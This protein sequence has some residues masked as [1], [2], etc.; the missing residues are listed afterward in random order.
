MLKHFNRMKSAHKVVVIV[1]AS[2]MG[3]SL[4]LFYAPAR[5]LANDV[6]TNTETLAQVNGDE[7]TVG[8]LTRL[9]ESYQQM[10]GGQM[11]LAQLGGDK[12]FLDGLIRDRIVTQ[13]ARR[14]NL[15]ASDAE[16]GA[17]IR[18]QFPDAA[19]GSGDGFDRYKDIVTTRY[20]SVEKFEQTIRDSLAE[21]KLR[22]F[23]TAGVNVSEAEVKDDYAHKNTA[24][25]LTYV[26]VVADKLAARVQPSDDELQKYYDAHK[27]DF[28]YLEAQKKVRYLFIDQAKL[29]AKLTI[30]DE[31]LR[32]EYNE[33]APDKKEAGVRAQQI[34]LKVA[35]PELDQPVLTK[36]TKIVADLRGDAG[37]A[38][39]IVDEKKFAD[40]ARGQSEDPTTAKNGGAL[41]APVKRNPVK[42]TDL[43]QRV[44]DLN[45][46]QTTDP[47]YDKATKAY[48]IFRRGAAVPKTFEDAKPELLA[49]LRNRRAYKSA[50]ELAGRAAQRLKETKDA[51]KVAAELASDAAMSP[52]EMI[53]ETPL[54]KPGDNVPDIGSSPQFEEAIK[55]LEN[56][57]DVG[58]RI[59]VKNGFA[60]PLL[61]EKRDPRIPDFAE[62]KDKVGERVKAEQAKG[63][64]EQA[65]RDI[66]NAANNPAGLK[67]AAEKYGLEVKTLEKYKTSQPL[68]GVGTSPAVGEAIFNL[69]EG[70]V[71][72]TPVQV[73]DTWVIVGVT[74][75]TDADLIE[76]NK[77]HEQLMQ[78]ALTSK[79][80]DVYEDYIGAVRARYEREGKI[81]I[82]NDVLARV[83]DDEA[84]AAPPPMPRGFPGLPG[85]K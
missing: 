81:K 6:P 41:A 71:T 12:R 8:D 27:T 37:D 62:V 67:A 7:V 35:T 47:A 16:V 21:Q 46:G 30:S 85:A 53:K 45:E 4:V 1:F 54:I 65:A 50:A 77:Q 68:E 26:P 2:L 23:V 79:R 39:T 25:D 61:V 43:T 18:R 64:L 3:L 14:L 13:E 42:P 57:G 5:N 9:R 19:A 29:G 59:P 33:L 22:A 38:T 20:G 55:P 56:V 44:L 73:S 78:T 49:S 48:Y 11:N 31:D 58:E 17:A 24:F 82:Y 83:G 66:A 84:E 60:I 63:R 36:A 74:K 75:R 52:A 51:Q 69:K 40:A 34:V 70:E 15:V 76:Y 32:A 72:K 10:F 80:G 28:R